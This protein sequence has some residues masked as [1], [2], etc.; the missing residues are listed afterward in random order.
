M[1]THRQRQIR[2]DEGGARAAA[3]IESSEAAIYVHRA[4]LLR[5][6]LRQ[7]TAKNKTGKLSQ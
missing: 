6:T 7:I 2:N 5:L 1:S 3:K 4:L